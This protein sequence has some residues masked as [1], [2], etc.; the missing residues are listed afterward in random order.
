MHRWEDIRD[1]L[2]E[3]VMQVQPPL[4]KDQQAEIVSIMKTK[5]HDMVWNAIRYVPRSISALRPKEEGLVA[6]FI[7][8]SSHILGRLQQDTSTMP[9]KRILHNWD[10]ETHEAVLLALI[11]HMKPNGSDWAAVVAALRPKGYTFTEGA[12]VTK[13]HCLATP[14]ISV[15]MSKQPTNWDA[16]AHLALLQAVMVEVPLSSAQWDRILARVAQKGYNYTASAAM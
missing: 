5:G 16:D 3:A 8:T 1:D 15:K 11:D 14:D 7:T 13:S 2:F 10:A 12:L 9:S 4:N 6:S